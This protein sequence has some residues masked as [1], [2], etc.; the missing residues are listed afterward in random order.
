M[1]LALD[2]RN[3]APRD[4]PSLEFRLV[5]QPGEE[6]PRVEWLG[7]SEVTA[8]ALVAAPADPEERAEQ[9][10]AVAFLRE[11]LA[12]GPVP[13]KDGQA[14]ARNCHIAIRTLD[15]ARRRAGVIA[16]REEVPGK[17]RVGPW[18]WRLPDVADWRSGD[19]GRND[20]DLGVPPAG[21]TATPPDDQGIEDGSLTM[22][23]QLLAEIARQEAGPC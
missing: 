22:A 19:L 18:R 6:H 12:D 16:E 23:E 8:R 20:N 15:R 11:L 17:G 14:K 4:L 5:V 13:A 21:H 10:E 2:K 1:V 7:A 9:D 3:L